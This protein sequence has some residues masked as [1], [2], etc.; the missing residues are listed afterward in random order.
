MTDGLL[1]K[2]RVLK[3]GKEHGSSLVAITIHHGLGTRRS[4]YNESREPLVVGVLRR[5]VST[6]KCYMVPIDWETNITT[7]DSFSFPL[8]SAILQL[9]QSPAAVSS[10]PLT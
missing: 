5:K 2:G 8:G 7:S 10:K 4:R 3:I 6:L 1:A 9:L